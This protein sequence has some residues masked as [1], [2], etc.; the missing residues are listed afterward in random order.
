ML[1]EQSELTLRLAAFEDLPSMRQL[2]RDTVLAISSND[3]SIT[4][5]QAWASVWMNERRW[6]EKFSEQQFYLAEL[7][8]VLAGFSSI[9]PGGYIDF[10]YIHKDH[11]R[12]GIASALLETMENYAG[13]NS[14]S[15]L[16][17]EASITAYPF[18]IKH[19]FDPL[20]KQTV[21]VDKVSMVNYLVQKKLSS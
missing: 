14:L 16:S 9:T 15:L 5:L 19:G 4:Q 17:A 13:N 1:S 10:L 11:Q 7:H 8:D 20:K 12:K 2:F 3:Y 18:F 6:A 21:E